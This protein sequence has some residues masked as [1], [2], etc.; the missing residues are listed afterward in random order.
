M[1]KIKYITITIFVFMLALGYI[2]KYAGTHNSYKSTQF[3][4]D[5]TCT[6][7]VYG[8]NSKKA[9]EEVFSEIEK[10]H[11]LTSYYSPDSE[12]SK[13][14]SS[15]SNQEIE[16]SS[17]MSD[18]LS[19]ALEICKSSDGAFDITIAPVSELW[20]F[21]SGKNSIPDSE[22]IENALKNV[23]YNMLEL[24]TEKSVIIKK[25]DGL[26]LDLGGAAKGYACDIAAKILEKHGCCGIID[27]GGNVSCVGKNPNS[28]SGKWKIGLQIPFKPS[29]EYDKT[30]EVN[31]ESVVTSGAYQ[32]Y[33]YNDNT[34][35]HHIINPLSGLP[36]SQSFNAVTIKADSSLLADC[37]STACFVLG[38]EKGTEL[39][40][41]FGAEIYY[42]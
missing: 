30:L 29:G 35:Y 28:S 11:K 27:L 38:E 5:T 13:I 9:A 24:N 26:K 34:L 42:Y 40:K 20:D 31:S 39:A 10:I 36:T 21:K 17:H 37:L 12:I 32:R 19:V 18:I 25:R 23:G 4:F 41:K 33:F 15:P 3:L 14:N 6:V 1:K 8:K 22:K 7:T 2:L 16:I